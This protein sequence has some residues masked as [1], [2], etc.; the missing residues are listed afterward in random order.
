[1]SSADSRH[2]CL[3]ASLYYYDLLARD[4][5]GV[6]PDVSEHVS[7]CGHCRRRIDRLRLV[8]S[9]GA[10]G[11]EHTRRDGATVTTMRGHFAYIGAG[12]T[13]RTVGPFLPGLLDPNLNLR[14]PTPITVHIDNCPACEDD[15]QR[16]HRLCLDRKQLRD[17]CILLGP[18]AGG[19]VPESLQRVDGLEGLVRRITERPE[20]GVTTT[21]IVERS[22]DGEG[23][24][25]EL[26]VKVNVSKRAGE[27]SAS[28]RVGEPV[29]AEEPV[30]FRGLCRTG[31]AAAAVLLL[32]IALL[33]DSK[34]ATGLSVDEVYRA[35]E[36]ADS[37]HVSRFTGGE[38]L[39]ERWA[40]RKLGVYV[41]RSGGQMHMLDA[42][43]GLSKEKASPDSPCV[44]S[45][46]S[47]P[48]CSA[49]RK[50]I[51]STM[52]NLMPFR[53]KADLPEGAAWRKIE[54]EG[55]SGAAGYELA[56]RQQ[57]YG[58]PS[59]CLKWRV[60]LDSE[61]GRPARTESYEQF[62]GEDQYH[63][64]SAN[65]IEYI[66]EEEILEAIRPFKDCE[67]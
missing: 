23:Q 67:E 65:T 31:L 37:V 45:R 55:S 50:Q 24:Y 1:M 35:M 60:F 20:S 64:A 43:N 38:P 6:P 19:G 8:L 32:A 25:G 33:P 28:Q 2:P 40:S 5:A 18:A 30:T 52:L 48:Q 63:L 3:R 21:Y 9:E 41:I 10:E 44:V 66:G 61:T 53:R 14:I 47:G 39:N 11:R 62:D 7:G 16:I 42:A 26:P 36:D 49:V 56:W 4:G 46:L 22:A 15:L 59:I 54:T 57:T 51:T 58:G 13:C 17:L 27:A 34:T 12:V 29:E